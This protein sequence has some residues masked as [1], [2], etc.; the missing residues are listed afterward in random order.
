MVMPV[1]VGAVFPI[2]TGPEGPT[3]TPK[4][5]PSLGVT[6][7]VQLSPLAVSLEDRTGPVALSTPPLYHSIRE[8]TSACPSAS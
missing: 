2:N 1:K 8:P 7:K 4:S 6:T 3:G 5:N